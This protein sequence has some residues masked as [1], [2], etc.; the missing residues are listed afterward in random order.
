MDCD[1]AAGTIQ[2]LLK[3]GQSASF[4]DALMHIENLDEDLWSQMVG[5]REGLEVL[6]AGRLDPPANLDP[7][8]LVP[9]LGMARSQY[10]VICADL[11][12]S[13]DPLSLDLLRES[14][15]IFL[16]TTPEV[17]P[18]HMAAS[19]LRRL[20]E[21][22]LEDRVS[23]VLNRNLRHGLSD[24]EVAKLVGTPIS[25]NLSN[26]YRGVQGSILNASPLAHDSEL[27][28][29][30]LNLAH[31]LAPQFESKHP[32][33]RRKFLEFFRIPHE[34]ESEVVMRG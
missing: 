24:S 34:S 19:R 3:L 20:R 21:L 23:L 31:C 27:G 10:E 9:L 7:S 17:V 29:E 18:L 25:F 16:V 32:P 13:L 11:P 4:V 2:F 15:R 8:N 14:S 30:I 33:Q 12:S 5:K 6:Q 28:K 22:G 26:D 1:I